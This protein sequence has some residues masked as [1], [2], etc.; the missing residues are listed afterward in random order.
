MAEVAHDAGEVAE[1]GVSASVNE[2][3]VDRS[4]AQ[5]YC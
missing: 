4:G 5:D 1:A 3:D 2:S